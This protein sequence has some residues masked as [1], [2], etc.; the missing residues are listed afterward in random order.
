MTLA[1][2][3]GFSLASISTG[4]S[5]PATM[6]GPE[7][8]ILTPATGPFA[9]PQPVSLENSLITG[10][11]VSSESVTSSTSTVTVR[12]ASPA[13]PLS[14]AAPVVSW[15]SAAQIAFS[16]AADIWASKIHST[17][18]IVI[19]ACWTSLASNVLG[20]AGPRLTRDWGT[21]APKSNTWYPFGLADALAKNDLFAGSRDIRASFNQNFTWYYGTDGNPPAGQYDFVTV[22]LHE[23]GHGLG[24]SGGASVASGNGT[25]LLSGYPIVYSH[26]TKDGAGLPLLG[27]TQGSA[28]LGNAL[29]G[30]VGG[31]VFF[32]GSSAMAANGGNR[33]PLY[34]PAIWN[35]GSSYSHLDEVFNGTANDLM[36]FSTGAGVSQHTPGPVAL[37]VLKDIG[38]PSDNDLVMTRAFAGVSYDPT[39][40]NLPFDARGTLSLDIAFT[41]TGSDNLSNFYLLVNTATTSSLTNPSI[42]ENNGGVGS[43][44]TVSNSSLPGGDSLLG[45]SEAVTVSIDI[46]IAAGGFWTLNFDV[47]A[48]DE[49]RAVKGTQLAEAKPTKVGSFTLNSTMFEG[50]GMVFPDTSLVS[51]NTISSP[52]NVLASGRIDPISTL[53]L[54]IAAV[55]FARRRNIQS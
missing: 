41:N 23:I 27:Y 5:A 47:V 12:Y 11:V 40:N 51:V 7:I 46:D 1:L 22:V 25:V 4:H 42:D 16:F 44:L 26:L 3:V 48:S 9:E 10:P 49:V 43:V 50:D 35:G 17:Q 37:G 8:I 14:C 52:E 19:D 18:E 24:F 32:H 28:A 55:G 54:S 13:N 45:N 6:D 38:W 29:T 30:G 53:L 15:N 2:S 20:S 36:T 39:N 33:V 21:T 31:G 34:S